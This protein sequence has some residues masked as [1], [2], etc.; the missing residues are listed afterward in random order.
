MV[1]ETG[2]T[3]TGQAPFLAQTNPAPFASMSFV[4][5]APL[6]TALPISGNTANKSIFQMM[7]QLR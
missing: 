4:A 6:E 3:T 7:G 2:P 5:N 1:T